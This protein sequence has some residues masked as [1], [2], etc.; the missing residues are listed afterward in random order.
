MTG[1][2]RRLVI[3][4]KA[5][6]LTGDHRGGDPLTRTHNGYSLSSPTTVI[7]RAENASSSRSRSTKKEHP[8]RNVRLSAAA[9]PYLITAFARSLPAVKNT[10]A[11]SVNAYTK[12]NR[13]SSAKRP[14]IPP[15]PITS[16]LPMMDHLRMNANNCRSSRFMWGCIYKADGAIRST[17]WTSFIGG[18]S[19]RLRH[20]LQL[21]TT[22]FAVTQAAPVPVP[23]SSRSFLP[24]RVLRAT[25]CT[26]L[27]PQRDSPTRRFFTI[28]PR[29]NP[30]FV[31]GLGL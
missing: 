9:A 26:S 19:S 31:L 1:D 6:K 17:M 12:R 28:V 18:A 27:P 5:N 30:C 25:P 23:P 21:Y 24:L 13:G 15:K 7:N 11:Q 16:K 3:S 29:V 10:A 22:T 8:T 20:N 4:A 2:F 14:A